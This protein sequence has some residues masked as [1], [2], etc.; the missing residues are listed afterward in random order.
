MKF[1]KKQKKNLTH[2]HCYCYYYFHFS[3]VAYSVC[4]C[5][6][7][8]GQI[9]ALIFALYTYFR[10]WI[11]VSF[12]SL[13]HEPKTGLIRTFRW[14]TGTHEGKENRP[15][16]IYL[17]HFLRIRISFPLKLSLSIYRVLAFFV[18]FTHFNPFSS[19]FGRIIFTKNHIFL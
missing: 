5:V 10:S 11:F 9:L 7:L 6:F 2:H 19:M 3:F 13:E 17:L 14:H 4:M 15:N 12:R 16:W 18:N 1:T 8:L